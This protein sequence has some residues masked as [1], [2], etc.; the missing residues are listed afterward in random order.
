MC[1]SDLSPYRPMTCADWVHLVGA[2]PGPL[3]GRFDGIA[4]V[5]LAA[6]LTLGEADGLAARD[7]DS[8]QQDQFGCGGEI[9]G[10]EVTG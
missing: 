5:G 7:V 2:L 10:H 3:E 4:V 6:G 1:S 8:G 9:T